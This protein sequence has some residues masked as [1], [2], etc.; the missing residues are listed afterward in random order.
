MFRYNV[1]V[2]YVEKNIYDMFLGTLLDIKGKI[3]D[4]L[5][6]RRELIRMK[7]RKDLHLITKVDKYEL[8]PA[9]YTMA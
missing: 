1:D 9:C 8:L 6:R 7:I 3:K 5:N 2:I 4:A